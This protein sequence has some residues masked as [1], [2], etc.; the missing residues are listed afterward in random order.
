MLRLVL[1]TSTLAAAQGKVL[2]D[3]KNDG[4]DGTE[5]SSGLISDVAG[6]L[7]GVTFKGGTL[8]ITGTVFELTPGRGGSW[9]ETGAARF[10]QRCGRGLACGQPACSVPL[11]ISTAQ[12]P[13][14]GLTFMGQRSS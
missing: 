9:T 2:H 13:V 10:Q 7:Y 11:A 6:N 5:P 14:A 12:L 8:R 3:F 1:V 4:T